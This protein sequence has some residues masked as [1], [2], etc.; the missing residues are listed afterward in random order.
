MKKGIT[1]IEPL[2]HALLNFLARY[3]SQL[4]K[5]A[6]L[7]RRLSLTTREDH[8]ALSR[9]LEQLEKDS[10]I[11]RVKRGK[12]GHLEVRQTVQGTVEVTK[13]GLGFVNVEG[14]EEEVFIPPGL[15]GTALSKDLVE[16]S[17]FA[18][19]QKQREQG[20]RREGEV[21]K[22]LRRARNEV[23]GTLERQRK[24]FFVIPDDRKIPAEIAVDGDEL[25]GATVGDKVVVRIDSWG[26][27]RLN[28]EGDV[29]E[30]LGK[31]GEVSAELLSVAREFQLPQSFPAEVQS[32]AAD[33]T[34]EIPPEEVKRRLDFRD[35]LCVTIDPDD[36][37]DF[38]DAVSL[39]PLPDGNVRLG[40]H[41][42]DVS[43][44]V[45][46]GSV[47]DREAFQRGTSVYF[48]NTVIPMLPEHLSNIV[49]S[50]RPNVDRLTF[51]VLMRVTP[52]GAVKAY[53]IRE[54][55]IRS[56]RRFTYEEVEAILG[57]KTASGES[58]EIVSALK[59]MHQLSRTLTR[60]RM[61]EGSIDF[62]SAEAKFRFDEEGKPLE[63]VKK[64]R[65]DSHRLVEE[66]MLLANMVVARHIGLSRK[67]DHRKPFLYRIHDSPDP[68]RIRELAAFV[69]QFGFRLHL[70]GGVS[71]KAFQR[72]LDQV[73][74]TEVE[75][76]IN[77]VALRSMAKAVYSER[78]I[79]HYGLA[80]DYYTHFTSPIRRYPD[81]VVH[82]LLKSYAG[83]VT[84]ARRRE[85]T[86][87]LPFV[88]KYSSVR[89]RTAMEAERA[90]VKVMQVEYMKRHLG[91]EFHGV[92]SGVTKYGM[93]VE[94][95]DLLVEGMIHVRD[96][97]DDYYVYDEKNY[98]LIGR[99]TR[100]QYRLGDSVNLKVIRV[101]SEEREIDFVIVRDLHDTKHDKR[102]AHK[103]RN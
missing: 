12:Y 35:E 71:S 69:Q 96:L 95:N 24:T 61:H 55:V 31:A 40:V 84:L 33:V 60:K 59:S 51:S 85:L 38:D 66:F 93:F 54:S 34:T 6:E 65:L 32:A 2:T 98:A 36:A 89:E 52:A 67:E 75:N 72:L 83:G 42:A 88:A 103:R 50:L 47:L 25:L 73:R 44:Y 13:Q 78:N 70:E 58:K 23:V 29:V 56:A 76:V 49:C 53:E 8:E 37:K 97:E 21:V 77:E 22:V 3:P 82:R 5:K 15:L 1:P 94:I 43:Y 16:V 9:A 20:K 79:G 46:E 87:R 26:S 101:N 102:R 19:T 100:K 28:P 62:E 27:S 86:E 7:A 48:P 80:F 57:G 68:D 18:Q 17:L 90:A 74:G 81:L 45:Q 91:D 64:I 11:R 92:V 99:R 30:V 14:M 39:H 4:F 41:I 10:R 63:I